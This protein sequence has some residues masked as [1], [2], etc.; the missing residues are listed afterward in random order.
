MKFQKAPLRQ[1][2]IQDNTL[3][4]ICSL[5]LW[6]SFLI[7]IFTIV[8]SVIQNILKQTF[9]KKC[10]SMCVADNAYANASCTKTDRTEHKWQLW[11]GIHK[12]LVRTTPF[13]M[14]IIVY[15]L[16]FYTWATPHMFFLNIWTCFDLDKSTFQK[17]IKKASILFPS[18]LSSL[19]QKHQ[20]IHIHIRKTN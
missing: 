6:T 15:K 18:V 17:F 19:L 3:I 9:R 11:A 14:D 5:L 4:A 16:L 10:T 12:L 13:H 8:I 1:H 2:M 7:L 20:I